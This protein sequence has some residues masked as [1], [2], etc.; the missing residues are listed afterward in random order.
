MKKIL[1]PVDGSA[2]S[3][4][5]SRE[6]LVFARQ[7]GCEVL[8][9]NVVDDRTLMAN[10]ETYFHMNKEYY[11]MLE[12]VQKMEIREATSMLD[13]IVK[14]LNC[15]GIITKQEVLVGDTVRTIIN[16]VRED[17]YDLIVMGHRGMNPIQRIFLGSVAKR[18]I[19][20]SP[21]SVLISRKRDLA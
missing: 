14:K 13:D 6:A 5:A 15:E 21:C 20:Y 12:S 7:F 9:L 3:I 10:S 18:V 17:G 11:E 1:V 16:K 19:E 2:P 4:Y 8:F